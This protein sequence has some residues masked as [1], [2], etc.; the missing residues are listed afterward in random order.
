V[1]RNSRGAPMAKFDGSSLAAPY[2]GA[3]YYADGDGRF[4]AYRNCAALFVSPIW[5]GV[6]RVAFGRWYSRVGDTNPPPATWADRAARRIGR[7]SSKV[8]RHAE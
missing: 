6:A 1:P 7:T 8:R 4:T 3:S 5:A 2:N